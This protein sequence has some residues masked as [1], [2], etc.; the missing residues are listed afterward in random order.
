MLPEDL[1]RFGLIPEFIGRL[2]VVGTVRN[3]ERDAL[4]E[5]LAQPRNALVKQ[6]RKM[7]EL[8]DVDLQFTQD[9]LEAIADEAIKR[10]TGARGLRAVMEE[11]LL[12]IMYELPGRDDVAQVLINR[13]A[14]LRNVNPTLVPHIGESPVRAR[15]AS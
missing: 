11:V 13:D 2:P 12:D 6:Y 14:V 5:I 3:L 9:A 7:F 8:E 1:T 10:V 15:R 4:V